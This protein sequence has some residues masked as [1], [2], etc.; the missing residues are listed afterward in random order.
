MM[1]VPAPSFAPALDTIAALASGWGHSPLALVRISGTAVPGL[2]DSLI[3][4]A[5][6]PRT[7]VRV[8]FRL[9]D[10]PAPGLPLPLW[11]IHAPAPRTFTG[12]HTLELLIPGNPILIERI[13]A[14][15]C[16]FPGVREAHP[17]EFSARAFLNGKL[18]LDQAEGIAASIAAQNETQL[19]AAAALARGE[20][21]RQYRAWGESLATLLALVE[22]GIDFTDQEDVVPIAPA[23][24]ASR[25]NDLA[26][27]I[28]SALGG[29]EGL[30]RAALT[31]VAVLVGKPNAGKSTLFNAL[32][33]R[34]RAVE[35]PV[36][37]TTRDA[38]AEPLDLSR[39]IPAAPLVTLIDLPGLDAAAGA[40]SPI[41]AAAQRS[42]HDAIDSAQILLFCDPS[43]R[44]N[45]SDLPAA[46]ESHGRALL[47]IRT[48]AD[49]PGSAASPAAAD[50]SVCALDGWNLAPLRRAIADAAWGDGAAARPGAHWLLPR[51]RRALAEAAMSI[52]YALDQIDP[53]EHA[54]D[55]PETIAGELRTALDALSELTGAISPDD[56]IGRIFAT[57]CVG[58]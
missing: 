9:T 23:D 1:A 7:I 4:P 35:S 42:A 16:S 30:E 45:P 43:G 8:A 52:H 15:L 51:H 38:L 49:L 11:A 32:L 17:G 57:F 18:S 19:A 26:A 50:L 58:K 25:L 21:G 48:K 28:E 54:L 22:A 31:P 53:G 6:A 20:T 47:R 37:G 2:I 34:R 24:L 27:A 33:G 29:R 40:A 55:S 36:A 44:F 12:E 56:I 14:R 10:S 46:A 13:L 41:D 3:H 39:D 5:P